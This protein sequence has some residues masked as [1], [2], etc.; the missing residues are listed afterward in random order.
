M[1]LNAPQPGVR[2]IF[3]SPGKM[4]IQEGSDKNVQPGV[5]GRQTS[6]SITSD[7][8]NTKV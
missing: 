3:S 1:R 4:Q 5:M 6:S 8:E 2:I 7:S